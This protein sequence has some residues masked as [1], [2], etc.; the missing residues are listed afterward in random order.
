M[1]QL[2]GLQ[3]L[4]PF[5]YPGTLLECADGVQRKEHRNM[6]KVYARGKAKETKQ[7][8]AVSWAR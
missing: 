4:D 7:P 6:P 3:R 1:R 5:P 2:R 8:L